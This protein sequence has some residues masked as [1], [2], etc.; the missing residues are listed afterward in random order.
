MKRKWQF[1]TGVL[2]ALLCMTVCTAQAAAR[3]G[4]SDNYRVS[5][6]AGGINLVSGL[7]EVQPAKTEGWKALTAKDE[8]R[9]GDR[10]RTGAGGRIE[11][12]LTP[13]SFLRLD[14]HAEFKLTDSSL[15]LL[16][17]NLLRG[18]VII[19]A[20]GIDD[21]API[22]SIA[23][24]H[25]SVAIMRTG[26]YR[27]NAADG[28]TEVVVSKGRALV[29]NDTPLLVKGGRKIVRTAAPPTAMEVAKVD[30]R[31][32]DE[33]DLWSKER[34]KEI[35]TTNRKLSHRTLA[36][37]LASF[38]AF[39]SSFSRGFRSIGFWVFNSGRNCYTF[40]PSGWAWSSPYGSSYNTSVGFG[41]GIGCCPA[42]D[43]R[44]GNQSAGQPSAGSTS[45][46]TQGN[47]GNGSVNPPRSDPPQRPSFPVR[48]MPSR[49]VPMRERSPIGDTRSQQIDRRVIDQ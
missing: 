38:S 30:K 26:I 3:D 12:L 37:S 48:E 28:A 16:S 21:G 14:E 27:I 20:L 10:V 5:A 18:A 45:G 24:P 31:E 22:V 25:T 41:S 17:V 2:V 42:G 40:V 7:A 15:E 8:L 46:G 9:A 32:R 13:G 19:E 47:S 33:F 36:T 43:Y 49:D 44:R 39:D 4:A 35:A 1:Q 6:K 23:T 29:G 34:A 11:M